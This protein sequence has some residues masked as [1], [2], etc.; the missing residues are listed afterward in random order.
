ME[1][2]GE[3]VKFNVFKS[4]Q[5]PPDTAGINVVD[6]IN[7]AI[8][9]L[10]IPNNGES[11][12]LIIQEFME[13]IESAESFIHELH[14]AFDWLK[15]TSSM[16]SRYESNKLKL[17]VTAKS[18][19]SIMQAPGIELKPFSEHLKYIFLSEGE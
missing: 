19:T 3:L 16:T 17:F 6:A 1:V 10:D 4:M 7:E 9:E 2:D 5:Y 14:E 11:L 18:A 8:M 15:K 13:N 12:E